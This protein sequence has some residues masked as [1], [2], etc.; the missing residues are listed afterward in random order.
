MQETK[1]FKKYIQILN[2]H[3]IHFEIYLNDK[4]LSEDDF[5]QLHH[6]N[7]DY[8]SYDSRDV[9]KNTFFICKGKNFS[10]EYLEMAIQNG[11][12][13]YMSE[14]NY[15]KNIPAIIVS[16]LREALFLLAEF[17]F[18]YPQNHLKL[19]GITGTK[20]KST[21]TL[22]LE[23]IFEQMA[24]QNKSKPAGVIS[25]IYNFDGFTREESSLTT[26]E[27]IELMSILAN[28]RKAGLQYVLIEASSQALKNNRLMTIH[29]DA[30]IFLNISS[31]HISDIEHPDFED[32]FQSKIK[33]FRQSNHIFLDHALLNF[34]EVQTALTSAALPT[35][36]SVNDIAADYLLNSYQQ[37]QTFA[38]LN[39]KLIDY[40]LIFK[41]K[42][43]GEF[44]AQNI[45][46]AIAVAKHYG[47]SDCI[48]KEGI[49]KARVPGRMELFHDQAENIFCLVDFAHNQL[50]FQTI[51]QFTKQHFHDFYQIVVFGS[52]GGKAINRRKELGD[53][54]GKYADLSILTEDNSSIE[55]QHDINLEIISAIE[56]SHGKWL[57]I[58]DR[59]SAI[60]KAFEIAQAHF[61]KSEQKVIILFLGRGVENSMKIGKINIPYPSDIEMVEEYLTKLNK[62]K[63]KTN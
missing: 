30:S 48:I 37:K 40:E 3:Q 17:Y 41:T 5:N 27:P 45:L 51:F 61:Q 57:E 55:N 7:F 54:A 23:S 13:L 8:I 6:M 26:P 43:F 39:I 33:I 63:G 4:F 35:T 12:S 56:K 16:N 49:Q 10:D 58:V 20:G 18:N 11:A 36:F 2:N 38:E 22:I 9:D 42:L 47:I 14:K 24:L 62:I 31:D 59:K 60:A 19:I 28:C 32:Y 53:I 29:F 44:N 46:A 1:D 50:S 52:V 21:T 34:N 25:S 15:H